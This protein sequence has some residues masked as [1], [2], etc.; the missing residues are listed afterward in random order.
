M[1]N[2]GNKILVGLKLTAKWWLIQLLFII[3]YGGIDYMLSK[4]LFGWKFRGDFTIWGLWLGVIINTL[5]FAFWHAFFDKKRQWWNVIFPWLILLGLTLLFRIHDNN[6]RWVPFDHFLL[7]AWI[8]PLFGFTIQCIWFGIKHLI[9]M[10]KDITC[11]S[12]E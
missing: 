5:L 6:F 9:K 8:S 11:I 3:I 10:N 1:D 7:L 4:M 12:E 2:C